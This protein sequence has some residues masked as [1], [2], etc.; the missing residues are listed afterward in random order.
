MQYPD[1]K[2]L[3]CHLVKVQYSLCIIY[4]YVIKT[5]NKSYYIKEFNYHTKSENKDY[6]YK[7]S[8]NVIFNE[9]Y[10][11]FYKKKIISV[12]PI[13]LENSKWFYKKVIFDGRRRMNEK[14]RDLY[15]KLYKKLTF[16]EKLNNI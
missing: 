10:Y 13:T 3:K 11:D 9:S 2:E 4:Y 12:E 14:N 16:E 8:Y 7:S 1:F 6:R 15:K 5:E